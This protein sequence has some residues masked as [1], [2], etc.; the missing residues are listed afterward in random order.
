M[1]GRRNVGGWLGVAAIVAMVV[2]PVTLFGVTAAGAAGTVSVS[3]P[4]ELATAW[5]DTTNTH[6]TLTADIALSSGT[7]TCDIGGLPRG[8]GGAGIVVDGGGSFGITSTCSVA[9]L[10][11]DSGSESVTLT[12]LTHFDDGFACG[13][14]GGLFADGPV[15]VVDSSL[16]DNTAASASCP[17]SA[18][19]AA[20]GVHATVV[21]ASGG[22][23]AS[24]SSLTI[25]G[26]TFTH[27]HADQFGGAVNNSADSTITDSTFT[28]NSAGSTS[29]CD[30]SGD[31]CYGGA[32]D[33]GSTTVAGSTFTG[34]F[35]GAKNG[36]LCSECRL[37][38]GAIVAEGITAT[39]STFTDNHADCS[40]LCD[41]FGGALYDAGAVVDS[42]TFTGNTANCE[43][44]CDNVGGAVASVSTA[45]FT[46]STLSGNQATCQDACQAEGGAVIVGNVS[47][48]SASSFGP[49]ATA[50]PFGVGATASVGPRVSIDTSHLTANTAGCTDGTNC[51]GDGGAVY[52]QAPNT[53][54]I[55]ASTFDDNVATFFGGALSIGDVV[56]V[57]DVSI[58]NSTVTGNSSG[59]G[60]AIDASD[61]GTSLTL[62]YDT[63]VGNVWVPVIGATSSANSGKVDAAIA[64]QPANLSVGATFTSFG[65]IVALPQGG[66]TNCAVDSTTSQGYNWTDDTS[67]GFGGA[68]T[69]DKVATPNDPQLN[70]LGDFGGPTPTM[71]PF[72]PRFGGVTSPVIDAIP[73]AAC[74]T[75]VAAGIT[76]DQRGVTRP[77][78]VGCDIGAV[79]VT[80][81]DLRVEAAQVIQPKFTG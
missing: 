23:V 13:S 9:R 39:G 1:M 16:S 70:A 58:K 3:T 15:T 44:E 51:G 73:S 24:N 40:G 26:S 43:G 37:G 60:G 78:L 69:S 22:A 38:G 80:L 75:G 6:I 72:T 59:D 62:A 64:D 10:L 41:N 48:G 17:L 81:A 61:V 32:V 20:G 56:Q 45:Q 14:G 31:G 65:T 30:S 50:A 36:D 4:G 74:Q 79:E 25:Q 63:I 18:G 54:D 55:T 49:R 66:G 8:A 71:L 53:V 2:A 21:S 52:A 42:S 29:D 34:N 76:T 5:A 28:E 12:G 27:N 33:S 7:S 77:Q 35:I 57:S 46:A 47:A 67:C 11:D 68:V 19:S